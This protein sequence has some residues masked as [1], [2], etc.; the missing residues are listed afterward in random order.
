MNWDRLN[1]QQIEAI[2]HFGSP[3]LIIAGAG[4]GKTTVLTQ[5]IAYLIQELGVTPQSILAITFTNK[6]AKEMKERVF[7]AIP[8]GSPMP[9]LGTFHAFCVDILRRDYHYL[10]RPN[11]FV[12][13]DQADQNQIIKSILKAMNL[14]ETRYNPSAVLYK[15][16]ELKNKMI[17]PQEVLA[18]PSRYLSDPI[19]AQIYAEYQKRLLTN[20]AVDFND[21]ISD[22]VHLFQKHPAVLESYQNHYNFILVDEYQDTNQSQYQLV[23][24]LANRF[25][26][27]TVVGDFDQNIYSWRGA[28]I[29]NMLNFEEDYPSCKVILLEQ[30][31]RSTQTILEAANGLITNNQNRKEKN[32]WTQNP[33]GNLI[34]V[35]TLIDERQEAKTIANLIETYK[36]QNIA[37]KDMVILYRTNAQSRILEEALL[38][39]QIPYRVFGGLKFFARA[40][41]KDIVSY[42]RLIH[43]PNDGIAFR[44]I[45]NTPTRGIGDTSI[46]KLFSFA[47]EQNLSLS[48]LANHP[49]L[50]VTSR[51]KSQLDQFFGTI[52]TLK[53]CYEESKE[54]RVAELIQQTILSSGYKAMLDQDLQKGADRLEIL[55][56]LV[57]IAREE[58]TDLSGFLD[59]IALVSDLDDQEEEPNCITLMT[60]HTAKGLEFKVVFMPGMEEGIL[61]HYRSRLDGDEL[62]EERRLCYVALT[63]AKEHAVMLRAQ[64]RLIFG[65]LWRNQVSRFLAEMPQNT[66]SQMQATTEKQAFYAPNPYKTVDTKAQQTIGSYSVGETVIHSQWGAGRVQSIDGEGE[67]MLLVVSFPSGTKK[68]LAKYA[69]LQKVP[70]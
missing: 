66:L 22:V 59:K 57:T 35:H 7:K 39:A 31:Y 36:K 49:E 52:A 12:I 34:E 69:P 43:N 25:Q 53:T 56:E 6:A 10:G 62:E 30:N 9:F 4:S 64:Q 14:A 20:N 40:E 58:E 38:N 18:R 27:L 33:K 50:P 11:S 17:S 63:R 65:E 61:P 32:L 16:Q 2:T 67:K 24:L 23:K 29:Q 26:N 55:S 13:C 70:A 60:I 15:I 21:L 3:L 51:C 44:R 28:N 45:V 48:Q 54:D 47:Q 19:Y 37:L 68:L 41:V 46:A 5:K 42:L 8:A 1:P